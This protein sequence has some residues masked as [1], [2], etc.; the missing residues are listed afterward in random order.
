VKFIA[1]AEGYLTQSD[2]SDFS[3]AKVGKLSG[4]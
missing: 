1:I 3:E 2:G 4:A